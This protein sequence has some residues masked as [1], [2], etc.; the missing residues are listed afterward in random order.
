MAEGARQKTMNPQQERSAV[1]GETTGGVELAL[2]H[3]SR[4]LDTDAML[5]AEQARAILDVVPRHPMA[6]LIL[7]IAARRGGDPEGAVAE[8]EPLAA[9]QPGA[10]AVHCE[11]GLAYGDL[12]RGEAAI[13]SLRRAV[14]LKPGLAEAWKALG[15]HLAATGDAAAAD[16]A[17]AN[18]IKAATRDP[19]L[20]APAAALVDDRIPE[21]EAML[22]EHLRRHPEDVAAIRMLAEVAAR[23][24]RY[25]DAE[26][27]L[28]RCLELAPGF[29]AARQ[30]HA[31]V[32]HKQHR[33]A[34]ALP[35]L[36]SLL[37]D[38][39]G[40]PQLRATRASMLSRLGEFG[41]AIECY[42]GLLADY[43]GHAKVW[44]SYGH[45]LKTAG[46]QQEAIEAYR[47]C[48][49]LAPALGEAWWSLANLKTFRFDEADVAAMQAA[50][51]GPDLADEDRLHFSFALGKALEDAGRYADSFRYYAAGNDVQRRRIAYRAADI[52]AEVRRT[53]EFF[54]AETLGRMARHG[55]P[56]PDPI[57]IVGLPRSG[58]TLLEQILASHSQ[59]E[60][61]MELP[62]IPAIAAEL[63]GRRRPG[64]ARYPRA[65]ASLDGAALRALG[66]K[67]LERTRVQRK[68]DAP[69]FIDKMPNNWLHVGLILSILPNARIVDAR[70][71]PMSCCF[72]NFKQ[73][74]ARGQH[75]TY[76]LPD[77]GRYY[78]GY[79]ELMAHFDAIAPGRVHRVLYERMVEDPEGETRRL[80]DY[81]GL[82]FEDACLRFYEN[83]RAVRTASSEQVRSPIYRDAVEQWRRYEPWLGPLVE[84]LGPVLD[85]YPDSP[86]PEPNDPA[87][88]AGGR[89]T[90]GELDH[91]TQP[92]P[93]A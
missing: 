59:V 27:L 20:L 79:V 70:R 60:G 19:R 63:G 48:I 69:F 45:A 73:H 58:S 36:E 24:G 66:E 93:Q 91:D 8:L 72:S 15:D 77:I 92:T 61:T 64:E 42:G 39:P 2:A 49:A 4:L 43:P 65:L 85:A 46:R 29:T 30:H 89:T 62:D 14:S 37:A 26:Q 54:E 41:A 76:S 87:E 31:L 47:R 86:D 32:L 35:L 71:H 17:Y 5:A 28:V 21:A 51:A 22:R 53:R 56:A 74:F 81:C 33:T 1:A 9:T 68:T 52:A 7:G 23:L 90:T 38:D 78:R 44:M 13:A 16:A 12:G 18:Q 82:P 34:E 25:G 6:R 75:F 57:F 11:L 10:P 80:L 3:A 88:R 50:L 84:A 55:C 83:D 67:Y 40:N